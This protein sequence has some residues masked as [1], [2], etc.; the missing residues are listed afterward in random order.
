VKTL[1]IVLIITVAPLFAA[2]A[3]QAEPVAA[4]TPT[5]VAADITEPACAPSEPEEPEE[6]EEPEDEEAGPEEARSEEVRS[7]L[8]PPATTGER[9]SSSVSAPAPSKPT[10]CRRAPVATLR[11]DAKRLRRLKGKRRRNAE[12]R[13]DRALCR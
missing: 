12:R 1:A 5:V 6:A 4:C 2:A 10:L 7:D 9:V 3:V 8:A 13:L 11:A